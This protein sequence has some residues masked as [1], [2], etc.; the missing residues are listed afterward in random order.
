MKTALGLLLLLAT[1]AAG[2]ESRIPYWTIGPGWGTSGGSG[3]SLLSITGQDFATTMSGGGARISQGILAVRLQYGP[4]TGVDEPVMR[5]H[6]FEL[7][8]NYPNPFNGE[9]RI[10]Y[11]VRGPGGGEWVRL[12]VYDILGR[13]VGTLVDGFMDAGEHTVAFDGAGLASG[14]Y[15][16]RI[17]AG[18]CVATKKM[19]LMK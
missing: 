12:K 19:M 2:Q 15:I 10:R 9:T 8:Q 11:N 6:S 14:P 5:P 16:Y 4:Q 13:E 7:A 3:T 18:S 17:V 1:T